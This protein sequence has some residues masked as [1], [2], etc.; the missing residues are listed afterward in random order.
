MW[1]IDSSLPNRLLGTCDG[2]VAAMAV[3]A[4]GKVVAAGS[5]N[6][7]VFVWEV[8]EGVEAMHYKLDGLIV[9]AVAFDPDGKTLFVST[10]DG[11]VIAINIRSGKSIWASIGNGTDVVDM[12]F[13]EQSNALLTVTHSNTIQMLDALTGN[14]LETGVATGAPLRDIVV[15][16]VGS[17]FAVA[18]ANGTIGIWD[19]EHFGPIASF[20]TANTIECI[21]VSSD[22]YRLA[23]AGGAGKITLLDGMSHGA[24]HVNK[25]P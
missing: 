8:K 7:Q 20:L 4:N 19:I 24:R 15:F 11:N 10:N 18:H 23:I 17:R 2:Q 1:D 14:V 5:F 22:G 9:L 16:P 25:K 13:A 21:D 3:S 6:G 12:D